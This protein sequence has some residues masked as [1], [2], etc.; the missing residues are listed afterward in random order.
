MAATHF[1]PKV[2]TGLWLRLIWLRRPHFES[3]TNISTTIS[4]LTT[5]W[6]RCGNYRVHW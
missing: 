6:M 5:E 4:R 3:E 2:P 1:I